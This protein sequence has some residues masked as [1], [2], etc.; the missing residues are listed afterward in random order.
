MVTTYSQENVTLIKVVERVPTPLGPLI[1][2]WLVDNQYGPVVTFPRAATTM[3]LMLSFIISKCLHGLRKEVSE[4]IFRREVSASIFQRRLHTVGTEKIQ[5]D[6]KR[7]SCVQD[8]VS[9]IECLFLQ[10]WLSFVFMSISCVCLFVCLLLS[11]LPC[12][13][14]KGEEAI[15][16]QQ[17]PTI[18]SSQRQLT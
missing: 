2:T 4:S 14:E 11:S 13:Q 5:C 17:S 3:P 1:D 9:K 7:F 16:R 10:T 15:P 12:Q 6:N 8:S 18:K